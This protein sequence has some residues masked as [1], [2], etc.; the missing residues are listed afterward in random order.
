[1]YHFYVFAD[2]T[3]NLQ[4]NI[5]EGIAR[6]KRKVPNEKAPGS[7]RQ[8]AEELNE[9]THENCNDMANK[10]LQKTQAQVKIGLLFVINKIHAAKACFISHLPLHLL[11][12]T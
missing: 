7:Q 11:F 1:M 10:T 2:F 3:G 8:R 5:K 6:I 9:S 12:H 4:T